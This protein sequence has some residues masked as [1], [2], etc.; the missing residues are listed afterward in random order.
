MKKLLLSLSSFIVLT[1]NAQLYITEWDVAGIGKMLTQ[2]HDTLIPLTPGS[3]N[4]GPSGLNKTWNFSTLGAHII[5]TLTF[6]NPAWLPN[7]SNFPSANLAIVNSSDGSE[8]YLDKLPSGLFIEGVYGDLGAG[9]LIIPF[10][11]KEQI[12]AFVDTFNAS[13]V[14]NSKIDFQFPFNQPPVDSARVKHIAD[15][16]VLTD[17]SGNIT[18]PL[19][20]YNSLR[21]R[22]RVINTDTVWI[23]APAFGGW[24]IYQATI[25]TLWHFSWW[26]TGVGY[27]LLEFDSTKADTIKN[28]QW[29]KTLP[30][31]GA[32]HETSAVKQLTI[33]PNP[34]A[35]QINFEINNT[36]ISSI[37]IFDM[38][39]RK[40]TSL[41]ANKSKNIITY[42]VDVLPSGTYFF[43]INN[44]TWV[45]FCKQ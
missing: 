43:R 40:I 3:I 6:T 30:V 13:Y 18:T 35:S 45:K 5:D 8:I 41:P 33:Y 27:S 2:A 39:G 44:N 26:T 24:V 17:G 10:N 7:G 31:L 4:P 12:A 15:K 22:G 23:H 29:L 37:E 9:P 14:N 25:D 19:G 20:T 11:P 36:E 38:A 34:T 28:V 21:H 1:V 32:V 16:S 42:N